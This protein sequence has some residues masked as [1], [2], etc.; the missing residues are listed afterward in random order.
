MFKPGT[1]INQAMLVKSSEIA[2]TKNGKDYLSTILTTGKEDIK[3]VKWDTD[4]APAP[5]AVV[6]VEA[7]VTEWNGTPQLTI[8]RLLL[9]TELDPSEFAPQSPV[10]VDTLWFN[11]QRLIEDIETVTLQD[12]VAALYDNYKP[13]LLKAPAAKGAHHAYVGGLLYH[14]TSMADMA[15]S[16]AQQTG[17]SADL[18]I[19]GALLHD[20]GKLHAYQMDIATIDMTE[21]GILLDHMMLG[22]RMLVDWVPQ[23]YLRDL[24]HI[25]LSHHGTKEMGSPVTPKF[26]EAWIIHLV[27]MLDSRAAMIREN[28]VPNSIWTKKQWFMEPQLIR[29]DGYEN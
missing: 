2:K 28:E 20:I 27:D 24:Q 9:N 11:A 3:G 17:A 21:D 15:A 12:S 13:Y 10:S 7:K 14:S 29:R 5:N 22:C 6:D 1:T 18:C 25:I 8:S 26:L 23:P 19:A 16:L 4:R